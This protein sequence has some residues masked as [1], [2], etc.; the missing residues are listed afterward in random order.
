MSFADI[1]YINGKIYTQDDSN[2]VAEAAAIKGKKFMRV[3][4]T[5][6]CMKLAG[7]DT[8][9]TDL[10]GRTVLPGFLDGHTHPTTVAKTFWHIRMPRSHDRETLY[11]TIKEYSEKYPKEDVPYFYGESYYAE[12][13]GTEGP[14]KEELDRLISDRPA[15]IQDFTDHACWYNSMALEMLGIDDGTGHVESPIGEAEFI[16]DE[17]GNATGWALEAAPDGDLGIYEALGWYPPK[18]TEEE[19]AAPFLDL[20][21][22]YGVIC[23]MDGFTEGEEAIRMFYEMDAKGALN[24][25]YEG[26]SMMSNV[27][28]IDE[29]IARLREWQE[30]YTSEHVHINTIK[31]FIDGTNEMGDSASL[32]PMKNDPSGT[33]YGMAGTDAAQ[34]ADVLVRLNEE[35]IDIHIHVVC[36]RGFHICCDAVEKAREICGEEWRIYVTLAHCELIHPDDMKRVAKLGIFIDWTTHWSGGYFGEAAIEYLGRDRWDTMYDFTEIIADGGIVGFS[37]DLFSY[38][39][40][41]RGNPYFGIQ[42]AMTRVDPEMPLDPSRYPGSVRPPEKAKLSLEELIRGYTVN[43][44]VRMRLDDKLGSIAAGKLANMV[45]L[46]RDIYAMPADQIKDVRPVITIFEGCVQKLRDVEF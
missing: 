37:S 19:M 43:N 36:D 10:E 12:T 2:P 20:L 13:F 23:L 33:N 18:G 30:K 39:E 32:E 24:M 35:N 11:R 7:K 46:D 40:A 42:T 38:Q 28:E 17:T 44:A 34:L 29:A 27:G 45:V 22:R 21:K 8:K 15:R 9:V 4:S 31:F 41:N 6:Q 16:R 25:F 14:R 26:T 3:G 1:I 5:S